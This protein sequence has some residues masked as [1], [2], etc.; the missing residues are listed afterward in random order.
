MTSLKQLSQE[1]RSDKELLVEVELEKAR[2][3]ADAFNEFVLKDE[4]GRNIIL[5]EIHREFNWH[6]DECRRLK[7]NCGILAPW[8]HGKTDGVVISRALQFIGEDVNNRIFIVCN[9]DNNAKARVSSIGKYIEKDKDYHLT[10][11]QV[12]PG[13]KE[14][15]SKHKLVVERDSKSKDGSIEAWGIMTSGTGSRCDFLIVDDPVDLRNAVLNPALRPQIKES[16]K[17]VWMSRLSTN[18]FV[19]YIAT[20]WHEDDLTSE[21]L[22]NPAYCFLVMKISEDF[23][24][25]ECESPLKGKFEIPLWEAVWPKEK[26]I[27]KRKA[28]GERAYN[29]GFRQMAM[30]DEDRTFPSAYKVFKYGVSV[31]DIVRPEW[32]RVMG[33]DPF[34]QNIVI[35]TLAVAPN[36]KRYPIEIRMGKWGS[37]KP[38]HELIDAYR[39]HRPQLIVVENNAAQDLLI[40]WA[41]EVGEASMPILPFVTG[42]QKADP[43]VGL[44]GMEVEFA[45][46]SWVCAMGAEH[47]PDCSCNF[48]AW[49]KE[50]ASHP[51]GATQDIVMASWFAREAAR[52]ITLGVVKDTAGAPAAQE[53]EEIIV[54]EDMGLEHV[55]IGGNYE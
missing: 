31:S 53:K 6:I 10:Y 37:K 54:A 47:E 26:L 14:E 3:S 15:W 21:L 19:I 1:E 20:I 8:A 32:P 35:F 27:A 22:K 12:R 39:T 17:N 42:K 28:I 11:P 38:V 18:G 55:N 46:E 33:M 2:R 44:P 25:I 30:S 50:L 4:K 43:M 41:L 52:A 9:E 16:F 45:N 51:V 23:S 36:G 24:R 7:K 49:K 29:R 5:S 48:C 13:N 34:G 40:Q